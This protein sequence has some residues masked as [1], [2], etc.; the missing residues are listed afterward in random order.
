[1]FYILWETATYHFSD[2]G[3]SFVTLQNLFLIYLYL[4]SNYLWLI[5]NINIK[6]QD[7]E[8]RFPCRTQEPLND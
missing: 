6:S 7:P 5:S 2:A 4:Q 8:A 1:M 3:I